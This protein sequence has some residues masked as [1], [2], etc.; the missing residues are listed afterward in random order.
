M[1]TEEQVKAQF[2]KYAEDQANDELVRARIAEAMVEARRQTLAE[3]RV[4]AET[5]AK[6]HDKL[7]ARAPFTEGRTKEKTSAERLRRFA[8]AL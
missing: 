2:A 4:F 8:E 6:V 1:K 7:A 5:L 3:V